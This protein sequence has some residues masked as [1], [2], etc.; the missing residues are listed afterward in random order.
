V[1]VSGGVPPG[2]LLVSV[3][4]V[5]GR[6]QDG[7]AAHQHLQ[8]DHDAQLP[9]RQHAHT[10]PRHRRLQALH[11]LPEP[12]PEGA[13]CRG[14]QEAAGL[15]EDARR[16]TRSQAAG[17][18]ST[19][20]EERGLAILVANRDAPWTRPDPAR[21][22]DAKD[23]DLHAVKLKAMAEAYRRTEQS[24]RYLYSCSR[25]EKPHTLGGRWIVHAYYLFPR[26]T[27]QPFIFSFFV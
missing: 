24:K 8:G 20:N 19:A 16:V 27:F 10:R 14:A 13:V 1:Q 11:W 17:D 18:L 6:G 25:E 3:H 15:T 21:A 12:Q 23:K 26:T 7:A 9:R 5:L 2:V 22:S 4:Q